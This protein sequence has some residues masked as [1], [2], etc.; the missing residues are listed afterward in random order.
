M[1]LPVPALKRLRSI[2]VVMLVLCG[3][4]SDDTGATA[5]LE[6]RLALLDSVT[7][8]ESDTAFLGRP[9]F[10]FLVDSAGSMFVA[11]DLHGR[12]LR[13]DREGN[14]AGA[15]GQ[16]GDGPGEFRGMVSGNLIVD[17][18]LAQLASRKIHTFD[19][20]GGGYR[21]TTLA[22]FY[23]DGISRQG[24]SVLLSSMGQAG[25]FT[26]AEVPLAELL[27]PPDGAQPLST[28]IVRPPV[29]YLQYP[30]LEL[31]RG[32]KLALWGDTVLVGFGGVP[33]LVTYTTAGAPLDSLDVPVHRRRGTPAGAYA[34]LRDNDFA[35][36]E[37]RMSSSSALTRI[38]HTP[39]ARTVLWYNDVS[40]T[41]VARDF[42]FSAKAFLTILSADLRTAC[43]DVEIP[44]PGTHWPRISMRGDTVYALDQAFADSTEQRL[45]TTV[46]RYR[47]DEHECS[48]VPV[49]HRTTSGH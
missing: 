34:I 38:W 23:L 2:V 44:F 4:S 36:Y 12:V 40:V 27:T 35:S 8:L 14:F 15:Y 7:L 45:V 16:P 43:V 48:W 49:H 9:E 30:G 11:D 19:L 3:C 32:S 6:R 25:E 41:P 37:A 20:A 31:F 28:S 24:E 1:A 10:T 29:E 17:G 18:V 39:S 26:V 5:T 22:T 46:R 33:Y 21:G 42:A 13:F 47:I